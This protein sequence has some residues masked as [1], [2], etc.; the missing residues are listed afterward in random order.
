MRKIKSALA[1]ILAVLMMCSVLTVGSFAA[2]P[3]SDVK[4]NRWSYKYVLTLYEDGIINGKG[5]GKFAPT[6]N[7]TRAEFVKILGGIEGINPDSYH[8]LQFKD[9]N[10]KA[11]YAG[12][13]A[14]AVRAGVTTGT[15][16]TTFS[17][18]AKITREQMA[19]M[20]YRYATNK[21]ITLTAVN[22]ELKFADNQDIAS[23]AKT[24]VTA[25]QKAGIIN[26]NK[27]GKSYYFKPT[28]NATREEASKMLCV[29]Y[30]MTPKDDR[31][32]AF[33]AYKA[34]LAKNAKSTSKAYSNLTACYVKEVEKGTSNSGNPYKG[35]FETYLD[36]EYN[37]LMISIV[38]VEDCGD[39]DV[40]IETTRGIT[41]A[42][43]PSFFRTTVRATAQSG[44]LFWGAG[45]DMSHLYS[46]NGYLPEF[47]PENVMGD[48]EYMS[49]TSLKDLGEVTRDYTVFAAEFAEEL[50]FDKYIKNYS[51]ND[52]GF[53]I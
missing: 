18:D 38:Y 15:S 27:S 26:G 34:W 53:G 29:L 4:E 47:D 46:I 39:Y 13:V 9:V 51:I 14:W 40:I 23:Y 33:E 32:A 10:Y 19:V 52:L 30:S 17:P 1:L 49:A 3:F 11:W 8:N 35:Y 5:A 28:D 6:D 12:Y 48:D 7:I 22:K 25:M 43:G 42:Y 50:I 36:G 41:K 24:S 45:S 2:S 21:G 31:G 37:E 16:K 44:H 20:I